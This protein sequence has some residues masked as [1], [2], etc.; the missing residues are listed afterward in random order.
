MIPLVSGLKIYFIQIGITF[1]IALLSPL[2][3]KLLESPLISR[4]FQACQKGNMSQV[5]ILTEEMKMQ[6]IDFKVIYDNSGNTAL[7]L[8]A[9]NG[10][11]D[12]IEYL[13]DEKLPIDSLNKAKMSPLYVTAFKGYAEIVNSFLQNKADPSLLHNLL[14]EGYIMKKVFHSAEVKFVEKLEKS[15]GLNILHLAAFH[16]HIGDAFPT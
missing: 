7:H 14:Y 9:A 16:G 1:L 13:I 4:F 15:R 12:V 3:E 8:A 11:K 2:D 10:H 5:K 6:G